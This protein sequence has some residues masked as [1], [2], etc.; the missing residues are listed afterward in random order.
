[1]AP[2][3]EHGHGAATRGSTAVAAREDGVTARFASEPAP[4]GRMNLSKRIDI[5][6]TGRA[7]SRGCDK[8]SA[9]REQ[10]YTGMT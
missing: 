2:E 5:R 8:A 7:V 10:F 1:M 4:T 9:G 6:L 3:N